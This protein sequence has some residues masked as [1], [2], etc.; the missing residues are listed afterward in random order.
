M[1]DRKGT[2][3]LVRDKKGDV[4]TG[5]DAASQYVVRQE[6]HV[7]VQRAGV[8]RSAFSYSGLV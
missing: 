1:R 4:R 2:C 5:K 3:A 8:K 6:A 7:L